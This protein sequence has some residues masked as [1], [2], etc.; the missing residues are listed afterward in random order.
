MYTKVRLFAYQSFGN[1]LS[2]DFLCWAR[3]SDAAEQVAA[4]VPVYA[5]SAISAR[6][7]KF[8]NLGSPGYVMVGFNGVECFFLLPSL[9]M[10]QFE[11]H[12][13]NSYLVH[14]FFDSGSNH[15]TDEYEGI[16]QESRE[17]ADVKNDVSM[18]LQETINFAA[19]YDARTRSPR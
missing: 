2:V 11:V 15:C 18:R 13:A 17:S 14:Q 8:L 6:A 5:L 4:N 12:G 9:L 16:R 3:Y 10:S 7:G 19:C 1:W